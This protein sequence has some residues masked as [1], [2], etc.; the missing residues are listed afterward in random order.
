MVS[1]E[2]KAMLRRWLADERA[3][4]LPICTYTSKF[5][6]NWLWITAELE[7]LFEADGLNSYLPFNNGGT[8]LAIER[9]T[10]AIKLNERRMAWVKKTLDNS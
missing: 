3:N 7:K 10:K 4:E 5:E 2:L 9:Q 8:E 6:A 1:E